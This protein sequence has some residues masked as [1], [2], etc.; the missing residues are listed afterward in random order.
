MSLFRRLW[1][2]VAG[3]TLLAFA[4]SF[5]VSVLTA[6]SYLE[7]QLHVQAMD[8]A[9]ALALSM[10]QPDSRDPATRELLLSAL[11]DSGH[12]RLARYRDVRGRIVVERENRTRIDSVPAW[13]S[14]LVPVTARPGSALVSDGW[15]Q[16]GQVTLVG[17]ARFAHAALWQGTLRL[18]AWIACAGLL[19]GA[20]GT[21][22]L[23]AIRRPLDRVV[24]QAGAIT[25]RRFITVELPR[26]PELRTL[27]AALNSMVER[28]RVMF[29]EE[30]ARIRDLQQ[31]ANGDALTGLAN[32]SWFE[33]RLAAALAEEDA[34]GEGSLLWLHLHGLQRLNE[35]LG[36]E[37]CDRLLRTA[38]E[39]WATALAGHHDRVGARADGAEFLLLAPGLDAAAALQLGEALMARL[40]A[41]LDNDF[42]RRGNLAHMGIAAY[43]HGQAPDHVRE[44]AGIALQAALARDDNAVALQQGGG[45][46]DTDWAALLAQGLQERGFHLQEFPVALANGALLHEEVALRL[47]HPGTGEVLSAGRF[48]PEA[49]RLGLSAA[50]DLEATH[51]A[52]ARI[53]ATARPVAINL[54]IESVQSED[55]LAKLGEELK[56]FPEQAAQ[57]W[58]EV[59]EHGL[60]GELRNLRLLTDHLRPLGCHVGIDHFGRHLSCL[61]HLHELGLDYLKIDSSLVAGL[62]THAGNQALVR[63]IAS[64]AQALGLLTIAERVQTPAERATLARL[65]VSGLTGPVLATGRVA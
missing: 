40:L 24:E 36:R 2:V 65:G 34:A 30:A 31:K 8:N 6:R 45:R 43:H 21:L 53:R 20:L 15:Q 11:F 57:L 50:L 13:F 60:Q 12:F 28:V 52:L 64:V 44:Q 27:V 32:R 37:G 51:Q 25:E 22:L 48:M 56:A 3:T 5:V 17:D 9:A 38:G 10:S 47:R 49:T 1:L 42:G 35:E 62:D 26:I 14:A 7:Q 46:R 29:A 54:A 41:R 18:L 63:A 61:P 58:F 39:V 33:S 23:R 59:S 4:G 16:A 19:T 55:F